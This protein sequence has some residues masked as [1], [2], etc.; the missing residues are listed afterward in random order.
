MSTTAAVTLRDVREGGTSEQLVRDLAARIWATPK[1]QRCAGDSLCCVL[2][3]GEPDRSQYYFV[4][5]PDGRIAGIVGHYEI[6]G[7]FAGLTWS[8]LLPEHRGQGIYRAALGRLEERIAS[9]YPK[10][11]ILV[12]IVPP[13][14]R[15]DQVVEAF[16]AL[17][18]ENRGR[19]HD[20]DPDYNDA[21]TLWRQIAGRG[22][23]WKCRG[24]YIFDSWE[25]GLGPPVS[26]LS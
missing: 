23:R 21:T 5:L 13:G 11:E 3:P 4:I 2:G 24:K 19:H 22:P 12:E 20:A 8:G 6:G 14:P 15:H 17:G 16:Y 26:L 1:A 7:K 18:F 9:I 25:P 10:A